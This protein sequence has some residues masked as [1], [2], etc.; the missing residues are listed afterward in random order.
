MKIEKTY[1]QIPDAFIV[2][3]KGAVQNEEMGKSKLKLLINDKDIFIQL[4]KKKKQGMKLSLAKDEVENILWL[5]EMMFIVSHKMRQP[6]ANILGISN[7][8]DNANNSPDDFK[9]MIGFMKKSA[10]LLDIF[11]KE[12]SL[13]IYEKKCKIET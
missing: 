9:K 1:K 12:L 8:I 2:N 6:V 3:G 7:L 10:L 5:E 4:K 13:F 11:T